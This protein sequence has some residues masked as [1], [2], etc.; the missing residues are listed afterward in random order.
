M[1]DVKNF[2]W[3]FLEIIL[4]Q[5]V[6]KSELFSSSNVST[7]VYSVLTAKADEDI[8]CPLYLDLRM[9][10]SWWNFR[11]WKQDT[12]NIHESF[13]WISIWSKVDSGIGNVKSASLWHCQQQLLLNVCDVNVIFNLIEKIWQLFIFIVVWH[14]WRRVKSHDLESLLFTLP[15]N[16]CSITLTKPKL[17]N[18]CLAYLFIHHNDIIYFNGV[19]VEDAG[20]EVRGV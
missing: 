13:N 20:G 10:F 7:H 4:R 18:G 6:L 12:I 1:F 14:N 15:I 19:A 8:D 3:Y 5:K 11:K 9:V 17:Q 2:L 16:S